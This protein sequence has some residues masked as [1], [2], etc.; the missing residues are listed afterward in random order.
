MVF[1]ESSSGATRRNYPLSWQQEWLWLHVQFDL[2]S[3]V[4]NIPIGVRFK[5]HFDTN[6]FRYAVARVVEG[7][8]VLRYRFTIHDQIV[9]QSL[10]P[11]PEVVCA[12][13]CRA[14]DGPA[15]EQ[16]AMAYLLAEARR[17]FDLEAGP[18]LRACC[19]PS[20][21]R[22]HFALLTLHHL[23]CDGWSV[24]L[25]ATELQAFYS[26][27]AQGKVPPASSSTRQY[28]EFAVLQRSRDSKEAARAAAF[29][30]PRLTRVRP[31]LIGDRSAVEPGFSG[32]SYPVSL[33]SI[34]VA[35]LEAFAGARRTTVFAMLLTALAI[36]L[37]R[38]SREEAVAIWVPMAGR[39][40]LELESMVGLFVVTLP[41]VLEVSDVTSTADLLGRAGEELIRA[42]EHQALPYDASAPSLLDQ[43]LGLGSGQVMLTYNALPRVVSPGLPIEPVSLDTGTAKCDV[44]FNLRRTDRGIDGR[45]EYRTA[46]FSRSH[47]AGVAACWV[48][49]LELLA[50]GVE[51][52]VA[53]LQFLTPKARTELLASA[54]GAMQPVAPQ[55]FIDAFVRQAAL[56]PERVAADDGQRSLTYAALDEQSTAIARALRSRGARTESIVALRLERS[57]EFLTAIIGVFKAGAAYMPL[58]PSLPEVRV[59][60]MNRAANAE[61]VIERDDVLRMIATEDRAEPAP[62]PR[63]APNQLAYVIFTSGSTGQ[64]KGAMIEHRGMLNHLLAKIDALALT[65]ADVVA[66]TASN[67]FD[68][69][70]WQYLAPLAAGARV[71]VVPEQVAVDPADLLPYAERHGLTVLEVVP[72]MLGAM[73]EQRAACRPKLRW[74][75]LTGERLAHELAVLWFERHD[76]IPLINAYGPTECSDDVTHWVVADAQEASAGIVPI[77]RPLCNT[78][79]YVLDARLEPVPHGVPGEVFVGGIGVGRGYIADP[80]RTA[81]AFLPDPFAAT[82]G[83]RLYRTGDLARVGD[84]GAIH[85]LRRVDQQ[86]KIRGFRVEPEE[87]EAQLVTH[88]SIREAAVVVA[89][90][91]RGDAALVAFV[92]VS[93]DAPATRELR[94][95]L[96][97]RLPGYMVPNAIVS[98]DALPRTTSG[99]IDRTALAARPFAIERAVAPPRSEAEQA[100]VEIWRDLLGTATIGIDDDFFEAGGNSLSATR[101]LARISSRFGVTLS[102]RTVFD[103]PTIGELVVRIVESRAAVLDDRELEMLLAEVEGGSE[104]SLE[105]AGQEGTPL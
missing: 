30:T 20:S 60:C 77:G 15:F 54:R 57:L 70:V 74:M 105:G 22:E 44:D 41:I 5:G 76:A 58:A 32:S 2:Q 40:Q 95:L 96:S 28:G 4:Y 12:D 19:V 9:S 37:H 68:I 92:A 17:P 91:G 35:R 81:E 27:Y 78:N 72:S 84:G 51:G 104:P 11:I 85:F 50:D 29:W 87:I 65:A 24:N 103:A 75:M 49:V 10:G 83:C 66:Q 7:H 90:T 88:P 98:V 79:V 55:T 33:S 13:E 42:Q 48:R 47:I 101:M 18:P 8:D 69:S 1:V 93:G 82:P 80:R 16:Q 31:V 63:I 56:T 6:A 89:E 102:L 21:G 73:L 43:R 38:Y 64:P 39:T 53:D 59:A 86:A 99:K 94:R 46:S 34:L 100:L 3:P 62:C 97:S 71:H 14:L 26:L 25:L 45:I 67:S 52:R 23:V 61:I 36:V